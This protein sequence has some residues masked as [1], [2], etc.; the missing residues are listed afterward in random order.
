MTKIKSKYFQMLSGTSPIKVRVN[1]E[2]DTKKI[3]GFD[4]SFAKTKGGHYF[5]TTEYNRYSK[6]TGRDKFAFYLDNMKSA[7]ITL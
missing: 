7:N 5:C 4:W 1:Y 2:E 6:K 3:V